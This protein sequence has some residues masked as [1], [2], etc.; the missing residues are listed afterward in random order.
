MNVK[1][2]VIAQLEAIGAD[3]LCSDGC[4]CVIDDLAPCGELPDY[5]VAAVCDRA[6]MFERGI[7]LLAPME[8]PRVPQ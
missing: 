3:G 4:G 1:Q 7:A 2:M 6:V 8:V 5:C